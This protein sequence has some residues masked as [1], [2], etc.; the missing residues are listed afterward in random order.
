MLPA[1]V[2]DLSDEGIP[3]DMVIEC[4]L[5]IAFLPDIEKMI[6]FRRYHARFP[7]REGILLA[8]QSIEFLNQGRFEVRCHIQL[9]SLDDLPELAVNS[10]TSQ[11]LCLSLSARGIVEPMALFLIETQKPSPGLHE[12]ISF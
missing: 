9:S 3:G 6:I 8:T 5:V 10:A 1:D 2:F 7:K 4:E 11:A 12:F